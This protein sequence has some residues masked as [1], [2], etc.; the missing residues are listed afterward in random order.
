MDTGTTLYHKPLR[1]LQDLAPFLHLPTIRFDCPANIYC[2]A[3]IHASTVTDLELK[4]TIW[5]P[6]FAFQAVTDTFPQLRTL[7]LSHPHNLV[8]PV[9]Y[10]LPR[11]VRRGRAAEARLHGRFGVA[12]QSHYARALSPLPHL[13]TVHIALPYWSRGTHISFNPTA[14]SDPNT[15]LWAEECKRCVGVMYEDPAFRA[16]YMARKNGV[17]SNLTPAEAGA[18]RSRLYR[19]P[20][21]LERVEWDF[22]ESNRA[23]GEDAS[24]ETTSDYGEEE[25]EEE[26]DDY[27]WEEMEWEMAVEREREDDDEGP[28]VAMKSKSTPVATRRWNSLNWVAQRT[29]KPHAY[30]LLQAGR[31]VLSTP[32]S[33]AYST[34]HPIL[35]FVPVFTPLRRSPISSPANTIILSPTRIGNDAFGSEAGANGSALRIYPSPNLEAMRRPI[36]DAECPWHQLVNVTARDGHLLYI[37]RLGLELDSESRI[38]MAALCSRSASFPWKFRVLYTCEGRGASPRAQLLCANLKEHEAERGLA[39]TPTVNARAQLW[40]AGARMYFGLATIAL[41]LSSRRAL[42]CHRDE[43]EGHHLA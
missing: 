27:A 12:A 41:P 3:F 30:E 1:P 18:E 28:L 33:T 15:E 13:H 5:T 10:V 17:L 29:P 25:R 7:R 6:P 34:H 21:A 22:R 14:S 16:L 20:P 38:R 31:G 26:Y 9:Q 4:S 2:L 23:I 8:R 40:E 24:D 39:T 32:A 11:P 36:D 19:D 43:T 42:H 37:S 35:P